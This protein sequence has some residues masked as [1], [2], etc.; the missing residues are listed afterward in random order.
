M[1]RYLKKAQRWANI[2]KY[3]PGIRA[4]FLSG[5]LAQG[6]ATKDSDIDFFIL[7]HHG[8]IWTTRFFVFVILKLFRQIKT[9][10]NHAGKICPNHF[11]SDKTLKLS[12]EDI[13]ALKT[14]AQNVSL[15]D[16]DNLREMFLEI[17]NNSCSSKYKKLDPVS[18]RRLPRKLEHLLKN[19]QIKKIKK[20]PD[21]LIPG[22]KIILEDHELR[23]HPEPRK[24]P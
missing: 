10:K 7:T 1:Q 9:D 16:P 5:S 12:K 4:I 22:A 15:Y 6:K 17:N 23:F 8:Q 18:V 13:Y 20:N 19:T 11:M 21:Y 2:L 3:C 24:V 14:Y